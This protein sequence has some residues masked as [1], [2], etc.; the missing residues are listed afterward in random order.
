MITSHQ[1]RM[2]NPH[3]HQLCQK[4]KIKPQEVPISAKTGSESKTPEAGTSQGLFN[5]LQEL[6]QYETPS[7]K[8]TSAFKKSSKFLLLFHRTQICTSPVY[9]CNTCCVRFTGKKKHNKSCKNPQ[10]TRVRAD[11]KDEFPIDIKDYV[12]KLSRNISQVHR[13]LAEYDENRIYSGDQPLTRF[14]KKLPIHSC[15]CDKTIQEANAPGNYVQ[16]G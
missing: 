1:L 9:Q 10:I 15:G 6:C 2:N 8:D 16:L 13:L 5:L 7:D 12:P 3:L 4:N 11:S 14:Q